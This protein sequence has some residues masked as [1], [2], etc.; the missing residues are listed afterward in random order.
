MQKISYQHACGIPKNLIRGGTTPSQRRAVY[1]VVMEQCGRVNEFNDSGEIEALFST[2][3]QGPADQQQQC[4]A[5]ALAT[6]SNDVTRDLGYQR[7]R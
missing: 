2:I 1:H 5:Q 4:R 7:H 6:R 3:A